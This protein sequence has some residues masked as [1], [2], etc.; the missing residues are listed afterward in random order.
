MRYVI[1]IVSSNDNGKVFKTTERNIDDT[2]KNISKLVT[3]LIKDG[4]TIVEQDVVLEH[5]KHISLH[6]VMTSGIHRTKNIRF[7]S[8]VKLEF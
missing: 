7:N 1:Q 5:Y 4:W 2:P 6:K 8:H 3:N